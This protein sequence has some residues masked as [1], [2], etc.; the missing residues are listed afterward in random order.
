M[1]SSAISAKSPNAPSKTG[2][3]VKMGDDCKLVI[4]VRT[5]LGMGKGKIAAQCSHATLGCYKQAMKRYPEL[6]EAWEAAGQPKVVV[7]L[8][9]GGED[10]LEELAALAKSK[11]LPAKIIHDAGRTQIASGSATVVGIGPGPVDLV[12]QV[13]AHLK[14]L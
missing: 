8:D 4:V 10:G 6:L 3:G 13:T 11:R 1:N 5:D 7:K 14:L 9:T 2:L 12:N